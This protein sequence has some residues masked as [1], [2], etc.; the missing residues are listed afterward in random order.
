[1]LKLHQVQNTV[2][3]LA[4]RGLRAI[5]IVITETKLEPGVEIN[6]P[7]FYCASRRDRNRRGGGV[8]VFVEDAYVAFESYTADSRGDVEATEVAVLGASGRVACRF[9]GVYRPP[10]AGPAAFAAVD[11]RA[12]AAAAAD[13]PLV[14]LGDLNVPNFDGA[15]QSDQW[16]RAPKAR[17]N[18]TPAADRLSALL[19]ERDMTV[20]SGLVESVG[21]GERHSATHFRGTVASELDFALADEAALSLVRSTGTENGRSAWGF[22]HHRVVWVG[23]EFEAAHLPPPVRPRFPT[24]RWRFAD[25]DARDAYAAYLD[26]SLEP[27]VAELETNGLRYW[28]GDVQAAVR[29]I[30]DAIHEAEAATIGVSSGTGGSDPT[31]PWWDDWVNRAA[32]RLDD[33]STALSIAATAG[34]PRQIT[35]CASALRRCKAEFD[36]RVGAARAAF[37]EWRLVAAKHDPR[38]LSAVY[39]ELRAHLGDKRAR[40]GRG[41]AHVWRTLSTPD[42]RRVV[43]DAIAA[44][45][46]AQ[47]ADAFS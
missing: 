39:E 4:M 41:T 36:R 40:G 26:W 9:L 14:V 7:G 22:S 30:V 19:A 15:Q 17:P 13:E 46:E 43:G 31:P 47:V 23:L 16:R 21:P 5:V 11:E 25:S 6:L 8:A 20:V 12:A 32:G 2:A 45:L 3:R 27:V 33:A 37:F 44:E 24:A 38:A 1:M 28:R 42:G 34:D 18:T 29:E 10:S 35:I